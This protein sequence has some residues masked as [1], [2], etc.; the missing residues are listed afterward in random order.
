MLVQLTKEVFPFLIVW[1]I[2]V[3]LL[4]DCIYLL[5]LFYIFDLLLCF[6]SL[7]K[8]LRFTSFYS[9]TINRMY[10][11][12]SQFTKKINERKRGEKIKRDRLSWVNLHV[13][14]LL[15]HINLNKINV[16]KNYW[17]T[18]SNDEAKGLFNINNTIYELI[19]ST[20]SICNKIK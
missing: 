10:T 7:T 6:L 20:I 18:K 1:C 8:G 3:F 19:L 12:S 13:C 17:V 5:N 2:H 14:L 15:F 11:Q 4:F 9:I 16:R